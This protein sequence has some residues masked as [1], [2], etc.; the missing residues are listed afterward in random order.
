M[1]RDELLTMDR[2]HCIVQV[3]G[4]HPFKDNKYDLTKHPRYKFHSEG[5]GEK[6][7]FD[8]DEYLA[9]LKKQ[10]ARRKNNAAAERIKQVGPVEPVKQEVKISFT[11]MDGSVDIA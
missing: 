10:E 7:W 11:S 8:I 2:N 9:A 6:Y 3:I 1:T 4:K 5:K